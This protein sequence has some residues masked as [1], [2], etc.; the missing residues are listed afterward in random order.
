MQSSAPHACCPRSLQTIRREAPRLGGSFANWGLMF[1]VFDCTCLWVRKKEDPF[2]AIIAGA[3]TG[4]FLQL[5]SGVRPA[6]RSAV[7]GGVL[8]ALI[9]GLGIGLQKMTSPPPPASPFQPGACRLAFRPWPRLRETRCMLRHS[10]ALHPAMHATFAI[11]RP[12]AAA[13]LCCSLDSAYARRPHARRM[14][15]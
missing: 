7:F 6:F 4:G 5:R 9:E 12:L 14:P 15:A 8:L 10:D 2:N 3:A 11:P 1:A 13:S